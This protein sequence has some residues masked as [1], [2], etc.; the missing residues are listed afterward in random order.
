MRETNE[1]K[2]AAAERLRDP[3]PDAMVT[4][5]PSAWVEIGQ[6][7]D[8]SPPRPHALVP[9]CAETQSVGMGPL[10]LI[11]DGERLTAWLQSPYSTGTL[12]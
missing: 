6:T 1:E 4:I 8:S 2:W 12:P 7:D 5:I 3:G 11:G 9:G 10:H